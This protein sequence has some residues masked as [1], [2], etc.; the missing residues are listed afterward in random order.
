[1]DSTSQRRSLGG[2]VGRHRF[3][4]I[5]HRTAMTSVISPGGDSRSPEN[6]LALNPPPG[7][8]AIRRTSMT[9]EG[10][11]APAGGE[12]S[13]CRKFGPAARTY[14]ACR[15][16]ANVGLR[17]NDDCR[18]D[19]ADVTWGLG[20][21]GR[22]YSDRRAPAQSSTSEGSHC[23][24]KVPVKAMNRRT[25]CRRAVAVPTESIRLRC[26][27]NRPVSIAS[28]TVSAGCSSITPSARTRCAAP[29]MSTFWRAINPP[30]T[31][32]ETASRKPQ[33]PQVRSSTVK[34][35]PG[36]RHSRRRSHPT[37]ENTYVT[38]ANT[39]SDGICTLSSASR[40]GHDLDGSR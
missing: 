16:M 14:A 18:L 39:A 11:P 30:R 19:L 40:H 27:R 12:V 13:T 6:A 26:C 22:L 34:A 20:P 36:P 1:M 23:Q 3:R 8:F 7:R 10:R 25:R 15:L 5:V 37:C 24:G 29:S 21:S 35:L 9:R 38:D 28:N 33:N 17:V 31:Q 4:C 32:C 2:S